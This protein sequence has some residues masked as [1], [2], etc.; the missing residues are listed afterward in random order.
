MDLFEHEQQVYDKAVKRAEGKDKFVDIETYALLAGEYG[1]LL[2]LIRNTMHISDRTSTV[3]LESNLELEDKVHLD[4]LTGI[5]RR[6][7]LEDNLRRLLKHLSRAEEPLSVMMIDVDFFKKYNDAYG[8]GAGDDCLRAI[9]KALNNSIGRADDFVARY[10][11]EE[12]VVVLPYTGKTGAEAIAARFLE[13]VRNLKIPHE[14][15]DAADHI[16]ISIGVTTVIVVHNHHY[17]DY[18]NCADEALYMSKQTGRDKYT[19]LDYN[20]KG[21]GDEA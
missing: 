6:W 3:L 21:E 15:S 10:G 13:S 17:M 20:E 16:T 19:Y 18:I 9:A 5:Y 7:Y 8:H 4:A 1:I 12:F 14:H 2:K 11:G